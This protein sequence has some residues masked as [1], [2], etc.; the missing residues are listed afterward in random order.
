MS[1]L[2]PSTQ[3]FVKGEVYGNDK[4]K[5]R[6]KRTK[7][8]KLKLKRGQSITMDGTVFKAIPGSFTKN[9]KKNRKIT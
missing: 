5:K 6:T 7:T 8:G 3:A 1:Q 2:I 4:K 9:L